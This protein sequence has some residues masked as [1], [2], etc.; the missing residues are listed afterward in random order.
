M[1]IPV[2]QDLYEGTGVFGAVYF[3]S[4]HEGTLVFV[5]GGARHTLVLVD[6][7]G[8]SQPLAPERAAFRNPMFAPNG[9]RVS[10]AIDD[11][12]RNTQIWLYDLRG[13]RERFMSEYHNH[14]HA[15]KRD[16]TAIAFGSARRGRPGSAPYVKSLDGDDVRPLLTADQ[17]TPN[18]QMPTNWSP[19]GRFLL[20][21]EVH[22]VTGSDLWV[23][24][25]SSEPGVLR[26]F[27]VTPFSE[28]LG[29]FSPNGRWVAYTSNRTGRSQVYVRP[30]PSDGTETAISV[31]GGTEPR[32]V[33]QTGELF[34]RDGQRMMVA[35][36]QMD[37]EFITG[38]PQMLFEARYGASD[39]GSY[40][41]SPDGQRF[42][43]IETD[44]QGD[45]RRLEVVE[46][47][48]QEL[49]ERVPA[50]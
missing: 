26:E 19:D 12:P 43:M 49:L 32:W 3:A 7:N 34:F 22:P 41:V 42:V 35:E 48:S 29:R 31:A 9:Q 44:L 1:P 10:V 27:V 23:L 6:R 21:Y 11:D 4:S 47:W 28:N 33:E 46:N 50:P 14:A 13:S 39:L 36:V 25:M 18:Y 45:G 17:E 16:G 2:A 38:Q 24:D 40:D 15:W 5:S 30:F 37:G 8:R 20:L